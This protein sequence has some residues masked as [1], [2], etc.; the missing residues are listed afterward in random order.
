MAGRCSARVSYSVAPRYRC[1]ARAAPRSRAAGR[2]RPRYPPNMPRIARRRGAAAGPRP[3]G[4]A[5]SYACTGKARAVAQPN[6]IPLQATSASCSCGAST[7]SAELAIPGHRNRTVAHARIAPAAWASTNGATDDGAMPA[8]VSESVRASV[9]AGLAK[10]VDEV[11]KYAPVM[12]A[13]TAKGATE[14]RPLRTTPKITR[15]NPKVA[16]TSPSHNPGVL[17]TCVDTV[18]A[19]SENIRFAKIT[20]TAAPVN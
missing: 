4:C 20:P 6:S 12:Y 11:K 17:R 9:T 10:L 8:N 13:P 18:T 1:R 16:I 5:L 7:T 2:V 3:S 19:G 14:L 15:S